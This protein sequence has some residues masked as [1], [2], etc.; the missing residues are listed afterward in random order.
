MRKRKA[1]GHAGVPKAPMISGR[2]SSTIIKRK[3]EAHFKALR[4]YWKQLG[5]EVEDG[6]RSPDHPSRRDSSGAGQPRPRLD[7]GQGRWRIRSVADPR[8]RVAR[9]WMGDQLDPRRCMGWRR[10]VAHQYGALPPD[11]RGACNERRVVHRTPTRSTSKNAYLLS[12]PLDATKP[13]QEMKNE[14][15]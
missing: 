14:N 6:K 12:L 2:E 1:R 13:N 4:L 3:I 10:T 7:R 11:Q 9:T 8:F 15:V 5:I